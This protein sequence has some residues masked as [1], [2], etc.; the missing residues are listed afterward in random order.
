MMIGAFMPNDEPAA[1]RVAEPMKN[2]GGVT[3]RLLARLDDSRFA[4][5]DIKPAPSPRFQY[6]GQCGAGQ[7]GI[8]RC[9]LRQ[10]FRRM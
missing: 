8:G 6:D 2:A 5:R 10:R 4:E 1:I 7:K 9:R 3:D